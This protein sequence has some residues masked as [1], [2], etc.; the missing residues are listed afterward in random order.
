MDRYRTSSLLKFNL[1][2]YLDKTFI[3][4]GLYFN[5]SQDQEDVNGNNITVLKRVD[6][7]TYESYFDRWIY[8]S[9]CSGVSPY[10]P[11][12]CSG[13]Y[14]NGQFI[15]KAGA[16]PHSVDYDHGRILFSKV[17]PASSGVKA[18][19]FSYKHV[20]V[21]FPES[22]IVNLLFSQA[23]T[24]EDLT[25]YSYPS[26]NQRQVPLVVIDPQLRQNKPFALGGY[27]TVSQLVV[28][29]VLA[30]NDQ[31]LDQIVDI[32]DEQFRHTIM[33]VDFNKTPAQMT[34]KGD[35][36]GTYQD[37]TTLGN[38]ANYQWARMYI[39]KV[40]IRSRD[41]FYGRRR[42]RIDWEITMYMAQS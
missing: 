20:I 32:L 4:K 3:N 15:G 22:N 37:W 24:N 5:V 34:Y 28:F 29:H 6:D 9:D 31:D 16:Y 23:K 10:S 42:A 39:D 27:K 1:K 13:V 8:E 19:P 30:N 33:G 36:A 38:N 12:V 40:T 21:D 41:V 2:N 25:P 26:G 7:Y 18:S 11:T 14:I 17:I 35:K